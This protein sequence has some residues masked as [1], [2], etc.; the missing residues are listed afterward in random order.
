MSVERINF[1]T[2]E[3]ARV[4]DESASARNQVSQLRQA[5]RT[6]IMSDSERSQRFV[7]SCDTEINEINLRLV[8][9][10]KEKRELRSQFDAAFAERECAPTGLNGPF[11]CLARYYLSCAHAS[12][13]I[14]HLLI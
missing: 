1:L 14:T 7:E 5:S 4:N 6:V 2:K 3:I 12:N 13:V 10:E 9:L 11:S 8:D